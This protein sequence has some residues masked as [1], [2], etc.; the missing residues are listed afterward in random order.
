MDRRNFLK[1]GG[2]LAVLSAAAAKSAYSFVPAHNWEKYDFGPG[3]AV[4]DRLNQGPF[5][6]YAPEEVLE[7]SDV[8]MATTPSKNI[9]HNY[10]MGLI[11]YVSGDLGPP[12]IPGE[13][14][15]K[16]IEDLVKIPFVQKIYIRPDWRQVQS[17]PGKLDLDPYLKITL[18]LAKKYNKQIGFRVMLE[19]PDVPYPGMPEFL[20]KKV[21]YVKLKGEWK[22]NPN[23]V[24]YQREHPM[25]RYDHPDYQAAYREL[26]A[27]LADE[28]N[29][30]PLIDFM[31]TF[32]YGFWGEGHTW[33]YEGHCFPDDVTAE[34]TFMKMLDTQLEFWTKTPLV[35][36]TQPDFSRVGNSEMLDKTIRTHNWIRT[37]TIFIENM[38]IESLSNRPP[39]TAAIS[40][41]GISTLDR[42]RISDGVD[43]N[44]NII[45]HVMDI[46]A[47]YFS[48]WNWHNIAARHILDYYEKYPDAID[49]IARRIGYR[50]R[51]SWIWSFEKAGHPGLVF[52]MVNDGIA[53]VPGV[54]RLTVFSDDG[55]VNVSGCLDAGYPKPQGVRQAMMILPKGTDWKG[56]KV[57]AELEVKGM[58]YPVAW[59]CKQTTN[60]DG[61]LTLQPNLQ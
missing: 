32:M 45:S 35:T 33:P 38:Q 5:P 7:G 39:W 61:S 58:K 42:L 24:R 13:T 21:P 15:E 1:T 47:N 36:N 55:K 57:K 26:N 17:S 10:G 53:A 46:G 12:H 34:Q 2:S 50:V 25:P 19:N 8:V 40:E 54:L 14:L 48:I 22:G 9:L 28:F 43:M 29:G 59:A 60:A 44:E 37:D 49:E 6:V 41:V 56:L 31:D 30:N 18:D 16:S 4:P 27:M 3:P 51:P 20:M 23:N 52:G 11:V